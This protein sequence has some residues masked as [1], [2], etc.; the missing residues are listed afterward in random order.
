MA[1]HQYFLFFSAEVLTQRNG[2]LR[3]QVF[4][5]E[6]L[7]GELLLREDNYN[8]HFANGG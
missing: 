8:K 5:Y 1:P 4:R 7:Q 3:E 6:Q 2:E